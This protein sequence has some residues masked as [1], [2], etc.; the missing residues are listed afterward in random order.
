MF[1]RAGVKMLKLNDNQLGLPFVTPLC[2][3]CVHLFPD[4]DACAPFPSGIP[5]SILSGEFLHTKDYPGQ[6]TSDL[7][8]PIKRANE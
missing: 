5:S 2:R 6:A 8:T 3:V 4:K 1:K 7:F